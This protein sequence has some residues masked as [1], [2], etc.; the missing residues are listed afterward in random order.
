MKYRLAW[1]YFLCT[2]SGVLRAQQKTAFEVQLQE[3]RFTPEANI[4]PAQLN[5]LASGA[6]TLKNTTLYFLQ[7]TQIPDQVTR[8]N[9]ALNG[10]IL[11]D[12]VSANTYLAYVRGSLSTEVLRV[13][14]ARAVF[15]ID[16]LMKLAAPLRS[17]TIPAYAKRANGFI[18]VAVSVVKQ[19][20]VTTVTKHLQEQAWI[21]V[22]DVYKDYH[23]LTIR[24]SQSDIE[25]LAALPFVTYIQ[26][27]LPEDRTLNVNST[28]IAKGR[29]LQSAQ[30][31]GLNGK[32]VVMG[33]G[34][35]SNP[36]NHVD[37]SGNLINRSPAAGGSHGLHVMGTAG[38]AGIRNELYKGFAPKATIVAQYFSN[39]I[40]NTPAY[41]KDY[42]MVITNN[43]Y[44]NI[45]N[46]C[47]S[48]G[49]YDLYSRVTDQQMN[50]YPH[51]QHVFAAGNSG[52][53]ACLN[54]TPG[55]SNVLGAFQSAKNVISVGNA[56][57][58]MVIANGSSKGPVRDGRIKPEITAQGSAVASTTPTDN[59]GFNS[60]TSMASPAVSGG[61]ALLYQR[62]RQLH[63]GTNPRNG[64]MK[65]LLIN[66][67]VDQ[68]RKGPDYAY[69]FGFMNLLRS[70]TMLDAGQY[71]HDSVATGESKS[72]VI[73]VP[74]NT[75]H[76]KV[77]LYWNDPAAAPMAAQTLVN[78]L[79][80]T[81]VK[82]NIV[83]VYPQLLDTVP[84]NVTAPVKTGIDNIN[85][86]EQVVIDS[87]VAGNYTITVKGA[88]IAQNPVQ[89][90]FIVYDIIPISTQLTYPSGG[91][92]FANEEVILV[93]WDAFGEED[94]S[95]TVEYSLDNGLNWV[96]INNNVAA[97][98]RQLNWTIPAGV[99]T[100]D[101]R[102][103]VTRN[104]TPLTS[105]GNTFTIIGTPAINLAGVQCEGY[106]NIGWTSVAGATGYDVLLHRKDSME[107]VATM[108]AGI[109]N[110]VIKG[111]ASDT[112]Y[113]VSVR[114][115]INDTY[116]RRAIALSR[117]PN[118][119][120]CIAGYS[121]N[122]LKLAAISAP[123]SGRESTITAL[124]PATAVTIRIKNLDNAVSNNYQVK[125]FVNNIL[126]A[127]QAGPPISSLGTVTITFATTYDFSAI[128]HYQVMA[129]VENLAATD[130]NT[131]N[132]TLRAVIKQIANEP[133]L[134]TLVDAFED[135]VETVS[136]QEYYSKTIGLTGGERYDFVSANNLGRLRTFV[137]TGM[138]AS[139]TQAF[140][141]DANRYNAGGTTDS[142]TAT[143]NLANYD[144]D[145]DDVRLDFL[146]KHHNQEANNANKLWIRGADTMAWIPAYDL[147]VN[148]EKQGVFKKS[149]SIELSNLLNDA[150][151]S[152]T[153]SFQARW[154]QWGRF[155]AADNMNGAGYTIDD[156]KLYMVQNDIQLMSID[157][158]I[159]AG[160]ALNS[161]V[162][163]RVSIRNSSNNVLT[164]IPVKYTVN[165]GTV[166][167]EVIAT[168]GGNA[169]I[170][171]EF[172]QK[173]DL[174][175]LATHEIKAWV[176][177]ASDTYR[178]NDTVVKSVNNV[179]LITSFPHLES[180]ESGNG[181]WFTGGDNV[182]WAYGTPASPKISTAASGTKAWK[183][184]LTGNYNDGELSYLYSP[185]YDIS[186]LTSPMLSMSLGLDIEDC[187]STLCDGAWMEYSED[188][189]TWQRLGDFGTGTNWYNRQITGVGPLWSAQD[190]TRWHVASVTLP[191]GVSRLRL[192]LVFQ[193]DPYVSREG[194]AIDDIHI[195]DKQFDI[196]SGVTMAGP[197][198]VNNV[199]GGNWTNFTTGSQIIAAIN[200][201]GQS[202]GNTNAQAYINTT[203][204]RNK[205]N[206]YYHNRNIV[207]QPANNTPADSVGVRF[208]FLD[209]ETEQLI[210]ASGCPTCDKPASAYAL[211]V[212][213]YTDADKAMEDGSIHNNHQ[214]NWSFIVPQKVVKVPYAQGYYAEFKVN[215]FSEFWLNSGGPNATTPLPLQLQSF[216]AVK[217][218]SD[219]DALLKWTTTREV[220]VQRFEV[221]VAKGNTAVAGN[222]FTKLADLPANNN[223]S[224]L[225]QEYTYTDG[226]LLKSGVRYYR[227]K[228]IDIDGSFR[229][230]AVQPLLFSN[231]VKWTV[232]PNPSDGLFN[233][234]FQSAN[235]QKVTA[236]IY[237]ASG[238]LVYTQNWQGNG[239]VQK[240]QVNLQAAV[241][242]GG[243][244]LITISNG[245]TSESFRVLKR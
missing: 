33:V 235:G 93:T 68:G 123:V 70:V 101:A 199:S 42:G 74:A 120:T 7:F 17:D 203:G 49:V 45:V 230:S 176:D 55:Y 152:F 170:V 15:N 50:Q 156:I 195:Y 27:V 37:I 124:T 151:Q 9:L 177:Y 35:D 227:L 52:G 91:E 127:T 113:W 26:P 118:V 180:F 106:I 160:C 211:G 53:Y 147:F 104:G 157:T 56:N 198:T 59:Y 150:G 201:N 206:Q 134:I 64:L 102:V 159:V 71:V 225:E 171:Y 14:K 48:F 162:P 67:A 238:K 38:G 215:S 196:Y 132:D 22:N 166:I 69:G 66:G 107:V 126:Q 75:A 83:V 12:Y 142:L 186:G 189:L 182:S 223:N 4:T 200:A 172:V 121:D 82:P 103:R 58:A 11:D 244:Y 122:D 125:Y 213:K 183:T 61:L 96:V 81:V 130:P 131:T 18:D 181:Y 224:E 72:V 164:N 89:D 193:S 2:T 220:N 30:G 241:F 117:L 1:L 133:V 155:P 112:T 31:W 226:E 192:R 5:I 210:Q 90:Y 169:T 178:D 240:E 116:G 243:L 13:A 44:G 185:C 29:L 95:F 154:G 188:G 94:K 161:T 57:S 233:I 218:G 197:V 88:A 110:Y 79:D 43:S 139:G 84:G 28:N 129:V 8:K 19:L 148:Q 187:G 222:R 40:V 219:K 207:V 174:S 63:G 143:Y 78:N 21:V 99:Q 16:P 245:Q 85:N 108:G 76:L 232:Y 209:S 229:Y 146:F 41:I 191:T 205:N 47:N 34:D 228:I 239:F 87:A 194:I 163:V 86:I 158:P 92:G 135:N 179:P 242:S 25:K 73:P 231:E 216:T 51:L 153:T 23:M 214:L 167:E 115:K 20:D 46:D 32:D 3:K 80:L 204:V 6:I 173:A 202:L 144:V 111:L 190:Y 60:G 65:A 136:A 212:S 105:T 165:N 236:S 128:G 145:T 100:K 137:N 10:I 184:N 36:M 221:E 141:L 62:Y 39:I 217:T 77:M 234:V 109:N 98:L 140:T 168:I 138:A 237:D 54:Y 208:Y 97:H 119:G 114:A 24:C 175:V 149:A